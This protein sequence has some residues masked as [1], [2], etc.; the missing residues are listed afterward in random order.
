MCVSEWVALDS[1][2]VRTANTL[3]VD[4]FS[5]VVVSCRTTA[6]ASVC[7]DID[8]LMVKHYERMKGITLPT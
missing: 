2:E 1:F 3:G 6:K 5:S 7:D 8:V 4:A